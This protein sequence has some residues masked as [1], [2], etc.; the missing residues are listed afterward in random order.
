MKKIIKPSYLL[1]EYEMEKAQ[2]FEMGR[3]EEPYEQRSG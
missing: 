2:M 3:H 1:Q